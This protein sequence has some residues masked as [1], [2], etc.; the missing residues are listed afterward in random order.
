M[1]SNH[2]RQSQQIYSLPP[3]ATW[4]TYQKPAKSSARRPFRRSFMNPCIRQAPPGWKWKK[5][6]NRLSRRQM[7]VNSTGSALAVT[8]QQ[9]VRILHESISRASSFVSSGGSIGTLEWLRESRCRP[10]QA[11]SRRREPASENRILGA[12]I[13]NCRAYQSRFAIHSAG[14]HAFTNPSRGSPS[15]IS[16]KCVRRC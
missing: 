8:S 6:A 12:P 10:C 14:R 4:V 1:D 2:R 16:P 7:A 15:E 11:V 3:L 13:E 9:R 5:S